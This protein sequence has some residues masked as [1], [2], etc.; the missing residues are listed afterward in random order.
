MKVSA[1][2]LFCSFSVTPTDLLSVC[3]SSACFLRA[4]SV[5]GTVP[6]LEVTV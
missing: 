2:N 5:L 6:G 1:L 3:N 4:S